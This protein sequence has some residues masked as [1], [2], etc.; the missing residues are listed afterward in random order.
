MRYSMKYMKNKE[1]KALKERIAELAHLGSMGSLLGWDQAVNLPEKAVEARA[2]TSAFIS[3]LYHQKI[4]SL[5]N[6]GILSSL[7]KDLDKGVLKGKN[8]A[9]VYEIWREFERAQKIPASHVREFTIVTSRAQSVWA[10]ARETNDFAL[11]LPWL[12]KIV[13]LLRKEAEYVGYAESPYDA[14]IDI[15]EPGM[16]SGEAYRVLNDLKD[17]LVPLL[18]KIKSS[19][20]KISPAKLK[21]KFPLDKQIAFNTYIA[22][23]M[24]FDFNKGKID[25]STHPFTTSF[26]PTDVRFTTRYSTSDVMYAV[27]STVHE[28]G[29]GLYE[30]GLSVDHFGTPLAQ[31]ISLGIHESQ[32]RMWENLI[33]K[34]KSFWKFFYPKLQKDFPEPYK[35]VPFEEFYKIINKVTPSLIRTEADEVTYNLHIIIRFE[36]EKEMIE[37]TIDLKDLPAI[38]KAKV[39]DYLGVDVPNDTLGVLQDVHWSCGNI[40]YF[41]TYTFGNLYSAQFFNALKREIP[42][43]D[44]KMTKGGFAEIR[45]W[46]RKNIHA[47]GKLYTADKLAKKLT[48]ETLNSKYFCD[49]LEQK[50]KDIY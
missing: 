25:V 50:Y 8:A 40:G 28:A 12:T 14:L 21:G 46:L 6:D 24:G 10:K 23:R 13:K 11:F 43:I 34:S 26:H 32:S 30:Q 20:V 4:T 2:E 36:I 19:K 5:D 45:E 44:K 15:Y 7:K 49:Y 27:G 22:E 41:P 31:A 47:H 39:K 1:I 35:K 9:I 18:K 29:H 48:G 16:T 33:G 42:D 17:F 37:G 3:N 38:W